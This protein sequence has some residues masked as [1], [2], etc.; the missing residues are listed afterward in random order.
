MFNL[1]GSKKGKPYLGI[2]TELDIED[3]FY[4][5]PESI[6]NDLFLEN[7]PIGIG[8][9][10]REYLEHPAKPTNRGPL[11]LFAFLIGNVYQNL[12]FANYL[13]SK[14]KKY[15][16]FNYY[17]GEHL[18]KH[19]KANEIYWINF[20]IERHNDK[21][22][23]LKSYA[24]RFWVD[25]HFFMMVMIKLFKGLEQRLKVVEVIESYIPNY[26]KIT[27]QMGLFFGWEKPPTNGVMSTA[28]DFYLEE[29]DNNNVRLL[30]VLQESTPNTWN[31]AYLCSLEDEEDAAAI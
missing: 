9:T 11:D 5:I 21:N 23:Y 3:V 24:N 15:N 4:E 16:E 1:F 19:F 31:L 8:P 28:I 27:D 20:G 22:R 30:T 25:Y 13:L 29:K 26:N 10:W 7:K 12:D 17:E 2:F 14:S 18:E 6:R